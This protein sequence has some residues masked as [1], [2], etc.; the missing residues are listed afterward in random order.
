MQHLKSLREFVDALG[1]INEVQPI[2][3]EVDWNLEMGAI[4]RRSM[5]LRIAAP[6][7][8]SVKGVKSGFGST[9]FASK[10]GSCTE[11]MERLRLRG[12]CELRGE[13]SSRSAVC[14]DVWYTGPIP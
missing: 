9:I 5:D 6:L 4:T 3:L 7:F 8:E 13:W 14:Y 12:G 10:A 1:T 11:P 2:A